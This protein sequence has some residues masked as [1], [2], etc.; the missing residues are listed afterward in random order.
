MSDERS[1][2]DEGWQTDPP[3][4]DGGPKAQGGIWIL[5]NRPKSD[6]MDSG[7]VMTS[8]P[9]V[10]TSKIEAVRHLVFDRLISEEPEL[11]WNNRSPWR[12]EAWDN[13][14]NFE[15]EECDHYLIV[16]C[17]IPD[18][19]GDAPADFPETVAEMLRRWP[20]LA[21]NPPWHAEGR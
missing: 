17:T 20:G 18:W 4:D 16:H 21:G 5:V 2:W 12:V 7:F 15:D 3:T 10:F 14:A 8:L 13:T 19:N 9:C 1:E 11:T 6:L